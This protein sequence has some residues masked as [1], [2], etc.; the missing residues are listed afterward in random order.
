MKEVREDLKQKGACVRNARVAHANEKPPR[1]VPPADGE[2]QQRTWENF[3]S[4]SEFSLRPSDTGVGQR[5][6]GENCQALNL[7]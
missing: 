6:Q 1:P 5:D 4:G 2:V 3:G 7:R